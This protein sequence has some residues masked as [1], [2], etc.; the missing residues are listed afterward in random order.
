VTDVAGNADT[1]EAIVTVEDQMA[2]CGTAVR[3]YSLFSDIKIYPN[4]AFNRINITFNLEKE[5][6]IEIRIL[7][8]LGQEAMRV[9]KGTCF[10]GYHVYSAELSDLPGTNYIVIIRNDEDVSY[11]KIVKYDR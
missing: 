6:D 7:D 3:E 2:T 8:I 10:P 9:H 11:K 4:P 5:S 1:C